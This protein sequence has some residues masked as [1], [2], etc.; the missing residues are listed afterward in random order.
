MFCNIAIFLHIYQDGTFFTPGIGYPS[1]MDCQSVPT[2]GSMCSTGIG[3]GTGTR[4]G[5]IET[6]QHERQKIGTRGLISVMN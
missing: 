6:V 1:G 5:G 2:L 3:V 4:I